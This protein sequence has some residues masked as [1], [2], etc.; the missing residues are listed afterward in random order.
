MTA[1]LTADAVDDTQIED[2]IVSAN[3]DP[4]F[5]LPTAA[6]TKCLAAADD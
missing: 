1:N 3:T 5:L 6:Q 2:H 4:G